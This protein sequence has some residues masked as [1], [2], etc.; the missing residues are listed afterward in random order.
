MVSFDRISQIRD[1]HLDKAYAI[2]TLELGLNWFLKHFGH[3]NFTHKDLRGGNVNPV[4]ILAIDSLVDIKQDLK[5]DFESDE[6]YQLFKKYLLS[7]GYHA[8]R[9]NK[10]YFYIQCN[11]ELKDG[12]SDNSEIKETMKNRCNKE[13][14]EHIDDYFN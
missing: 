2:S 3:L 10:T 14:F 11:N 1:S 7:I 9:D 12:E 13:V 5:S 6:S 4:I 8:S